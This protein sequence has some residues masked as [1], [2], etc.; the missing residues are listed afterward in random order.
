M[1]TLASETIYFMERLYPK[2]PGLK[3]IKTHYWYAVLLP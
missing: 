3:K 1:D 2:Q